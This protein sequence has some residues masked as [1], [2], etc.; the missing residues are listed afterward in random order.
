MSR[1]RRDNDVSEELLERLEELLENIND[2]LENDRFNTRGNN[3]NASNDW[4][5][6]CSNDNFCLSN[7]DDFNRRNR[8]NRRNR[9]R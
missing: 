2:R 5:P 8:R 9:S 4:C 7:N 1:R 6:G 3:I